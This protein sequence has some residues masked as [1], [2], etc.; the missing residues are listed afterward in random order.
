MADDMKSRRLEVKLEDLLTTPSARRA[1]DDANAALEAGDA[2]RSLRRAAGLTQMQLAEALDVT[3]ARISAIENGEGRD[4]PSYALLKRIAAACDVTGPIL[5]FATPDKIRDDAPRD[6]EKA[7]KQQEMTPATAGSFE[8]GPL[9]I[10]DEVGHV[11]NVEMYVPSER[12]I[13]TFLKHKPD[14]WAHSYYLKFGGRPIATVALKRQVQ[15]G[16]RVRTL[17]EMNQVVISGEKLMN[18]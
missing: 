18:K 10:T 14:Y 17:D 2:V 5:S 8:A 16:V 12:I 7:D 3:Q 6:A 15:P 13:R 4:G 1:F 11:V 9:T